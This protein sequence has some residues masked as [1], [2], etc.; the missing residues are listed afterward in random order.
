MK[1]LDRYIIH[2]FFWN[3]V[4]IL[5]ISAIVFLVYMLIESYEDILSNAP[6]M[7]FV[8]LYFTNSL[9]FLMVEVIPLS[10]AIAALMTVGH[11]ARNREILALLTTGVSQ[12]R[13]VSPLFYTGIVLAI[14]LFFFSEMVVPSKITAPG[15]V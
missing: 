13:I 7:Y 2:N 15:N 6:S 4:G 14:G 5:F 10:V 8:I 11:M 3:F 9:P 12:K 1:L